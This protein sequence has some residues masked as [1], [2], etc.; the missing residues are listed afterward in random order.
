MKTVLILILLENVCSSSISI[1]GIQNSATGERTTIGEIGSDTN[2][3]GN[4]VATW[5]V[6]FDSRHARW[7]ILNSNEQTVSWIIVSL[8]IVFAI[9][10]FLQ[11]I[12]VN[13]Q[14][15]VHFWTGLISVPQTHCWTIISVLTIQSRADMWT[16]ISITSLP[17]MR[18]V[19]SRVSKL[20]QQRM[21]RGPIVIG[22]FHTRG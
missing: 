4:S 13:H 7:N 22:L 18:R 12:F 9:L 1:T 21:L 3:D 2:D 16:T 19:F 17:R 8:V 11:V 14:E 15:Q 5:Y 20:W 6:L 10:R